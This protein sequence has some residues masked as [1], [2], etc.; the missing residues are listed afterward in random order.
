MSCEFRATSLPDDVLDGEPAQ[1]GVG[2]VQKPRA[3]NGVAITKVVFGQRVRAVD[4]GSYYFDFEFERGGALL[5]LLFL[6]VFQSVMLSVRFNRFAF[7]DY[8]TKSL[9]DHDVA[10][11]TS[12]E[13]AHE[14]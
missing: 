13:R 5:S 12:G 3:E 9:Q 11:G 1:I 4:A 2:V 7:A 6:D 14:N 8:S 10:N